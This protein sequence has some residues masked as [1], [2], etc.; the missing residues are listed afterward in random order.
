MHHPFGGKWSLRCADRI[1]STILKVRE[2]IWIKSKKP[3]LCKTEKNGYWN[4]IGFVYRNRQVSLYYWYAYIF[5]LCLL[6]IG[7]HTKFIF[8]NDLWLARNNKRLSHTAISL[9]SYSHLRTTLVEV[10]PFLSLSIISVLIKSCSYNNIFNY[11]FYLH[12]QGED[13][14]LYAFEHSPAPM[15]IPPL[16]FGWC[17]LRPSFSVYHGILN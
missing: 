16:H 1:S 15:L 11:N 6:L 4:W 5:F 8:P 10:V 13:F 12:Y 9:F 14:T 2:T 7:L 3:T 17:V